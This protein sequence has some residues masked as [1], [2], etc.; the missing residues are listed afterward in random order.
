MKQK[1]LIAVGLSAGLVI[2]STAGYSAS[3]AYDIWDFTYPTTSL[4]V[5]P[6]FGPKPETTNVKPSDIAIP[7][8]PASAASTSSPASTERLQ[9][10]IASPK[11]DEIPSIF[12]FFQAP[13]RDANGLE[14]YFDPIGKIWVTYDPARATS[15]PTQRANPVP[16]EEIDFASAEAPGTI[17]VSTTERRLYYILGNGRALRY[18]V[19]VG[20]DGFT[21][22]GVKSVTRK[23]EWPDWR[24]PS[25]MIARR[26]DL[27]RF[28]PG[29]VAN[30][31]GARALYLG[32]TLYRIHG[33]NEPGTIG[34]AV[35][36]GC[37]RMTNDDVSDLY[38]RA[39]VG[40]KVIVR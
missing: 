38:E 21:W 30:P 39:K 8:A 40:A 29:G 26:P 24:P 3:P 23:S 34:Q 12:A 2:G 7:Q 19:G 31:L 36:S 10:T 6:G 14:S 17:I 5:Q 32:S 13:Q 18:G 25:E 22:N 27:P 28:M 15:E 33:S 16:R 20:R 1:L 4:F 35:S 37:F 9:V 11:R